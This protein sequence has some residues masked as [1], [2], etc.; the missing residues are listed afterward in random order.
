MNKILRCDW[1]PERAR[2]RYL[3]HS[4][5]R[6]VSGK[7]KLSP[8]PRLV[9]QSTYNK[10]FINKACLVKMAGYWPCSLPHPYGPRLRL[11]PHTRKKKELSQYPATLTEQ[12]LSVTHFSWRIY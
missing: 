5:L 2:W 7:K 3:S 1:L 6:T 8:K 4:G 10:S 11:G 12:T 9:H